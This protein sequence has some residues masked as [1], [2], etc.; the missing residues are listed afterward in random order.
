MTVSEGLPLGAVGA[1]VLIALVH[2]SG[3]WRRLVR[4][5]VRART[6]PRR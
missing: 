6:R 3:A 4:V 1:L 2:A 5:R